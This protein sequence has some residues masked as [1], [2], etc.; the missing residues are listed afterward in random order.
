M[1]VD[2][3]MHLRGPD[4]SIDHSSA[5]VERF[6]ETAAA[7]GVDEIAFTEHVYYFRQT[8]G[9]WTVP[10][11][12]ERCRYDLDAYCDAVVTAKAR[13]LPVKLGLEVDWAPGREEQLASALG[14]YPWDLL[15]GS[16]HFVEGLAIDSEPSLVAEIG[17]ERAFER[18]FDELVALARSG[19]VDVLA[20]PDL[21]K[22]FGHRV[23]WDWGML[24]ELLDG[25]CLEVSTA[26]RYK[27]HGRIY[28][29]GGLLAAARGAGIGITLAS[30]AHVPANVGRDLELA[31]EHARRAGH[32]TVT[33]FERR[34]GREE[35]LG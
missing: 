18:Y 16:V 33:V 31:I 9:I 1:I 22:F 17:A 25:V 10:Y 5:A 21:V 32:E 34:E 6:V 7:R 11:Q 3:H 15:L 13:G 26:G 28:P 35:P 27:P 30:D 4:E 24:V 2:Y 20:H 19:L 8:E 23:D 12:A 29:E 14:P